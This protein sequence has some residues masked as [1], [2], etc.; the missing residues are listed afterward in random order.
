MTIIEFKYQ[1]STTSYKME[2]QNNQNHPIY[3]N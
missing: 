1:Q 2:A 3:P